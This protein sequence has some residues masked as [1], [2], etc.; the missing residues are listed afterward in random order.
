MSD[1]ETR[2]YWNSETFDNV[3]NIT[4]NY[5]KYNLTILMKNYCSVYPENLITNALCPTKCC[6]T[7]IVIQFAL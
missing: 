1:L 2:L 7:E 5:Y 4:N 3:F 6:K